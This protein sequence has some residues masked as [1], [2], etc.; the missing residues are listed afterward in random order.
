MRVI[1]TQSEVGEDHMLH[2][3]L[4]EDT[5]TGPVTVLVVVEPLPLPPSPE[6]RRAAAEAGRGALKKFG[7][8]TEEFLAERHEDDRRRDKAL[9][10]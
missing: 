8:S 9:G 5:P 1:E 6:E 7:G 3:R 10:L 4:P 2:I